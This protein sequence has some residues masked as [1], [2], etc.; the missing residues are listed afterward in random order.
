MSYSIVLR[1]Q[2]DTDDTLTLIEKACW[3]YTPSCAWTE[4]EGSHL[5]S[6]GGSG[7]SGLLRFQTSAGEKFSL[8]VGV[9][10]YARWCNIDVDLKDDQTSSKTLPLYYGSSTTESGVREKQLSDISKTT[11]KG[12]NIQISFYQKEGKKLYANCTY[13]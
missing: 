6:M 12:K 3:H 4:P 2:N 5:L 8:I 13:A 11:G 9:H 7:T 1:I 10:N